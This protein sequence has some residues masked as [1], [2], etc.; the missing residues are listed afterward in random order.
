MT[1]T[2][3]YLSRDLVV[4]KLV[5]RENRIRHYEQVVVG[6][7][8]RERRYVIERQVRD[9]F[10]VHVL[11]KVYVV[12][13]GFF[14][15][16][17]DRQDDV[18]PR[19]V[20]RQLRRQGY[21]FF[22]CGRVRVRVFRM[23]AVRLRR[24]GRDEVGF[25]GRDFRV[26]A[27]LILVTVR[28]QRLSELGYLY[29][30][31]PDHRVSLPQEPSDLLLFLPQP[32]LEHVQRPQHSAQI[33]EVRLVELFQLIVFLVDFPRQVRSELVS[34]ENLTTQRIFRSRKFGFQSD[35]FLVNLKRKM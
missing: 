10:A 16:H 7:R 35:Y 14:R 21:R 28:S 27:R 26:R 9:G 29:L 20:G 32:R 1:R 31:L 24:N 23:L 19:P 5:L 4:R 11:V 3:V 12:V 22:T 2:K 33:V 34:F 8:V 13:G 25:R 30:L 18:F 6:R 17:V 15:P